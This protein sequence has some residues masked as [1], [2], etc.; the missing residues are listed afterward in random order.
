MGDGKVARGTTTREAIAA[1]TKVKRWG[2]IARESGDKIEGLSKMDPGLD[3][4]LRP[5][6]IN[7]TV[8]AGFR[9]DTLKPS[10]T[11]SGL[12]VN[13]GGRLHAITMNGQVYRVIRQLGAG[14]FGTTYRATQGVGGPEYAI[15]IVEN[16]N[17][18][19]KQNYFLAECV[20]QIL[21]AEA[22]RG[23][24]SGPFVPDVYEV[25]CDAVRGIGYLRNQVMENTLSNLV[26]AV[27]TAET[28]VVVPDALSQLAHILKFFGTALEFNHR[29]MKQNNVMFLTRGD[30]TRAFKLIDFGFACVKLRNGSHLMGGDY[31]DRSPS[32]FKK[33]RD[34]SQLMFDVALHLP[35]SSSLKVRLA[36]MLQ[37]NV[38]SPKEHTCKMTKMCPRNALREWTHVYRFL[39]RPNVSV[40]HGDPNLVIEQMRRHV[41]KEPFDS[42]K[43]VGKPIPPVRVKAPKICPPGTVLNPSTGRCVKEDG[44]AGRKLTGVVLLKPVK[45][46]K[47]VK[48]VKAVKAVKPCSPGK[49][50][51]DV[52]GRCIKECPPG[53]VRVAGTRKCKGGFAPLGPPLI[54]AGAPALPPI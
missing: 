27:T 50:R 29:D 23:Q 9:Q 49:E 38:K 15:K 30:G 39:D 47:T 5:Y 10:L 34:L 2:S 17:T 1:V 46:V 40:P 6:G 3:L 20:I 36:Q 8:D 24:P 41:V 7:T 48:T 54:Q 22:S 51:S 28:D 21:L 16:L 44:P 43:R 52:T 31:F 35:I 4:D 33:D 37:A 19:K 42:A 26:H 14:T 12:L 45:V 25:V 18:P 53:K 13:M 11:G 32:C